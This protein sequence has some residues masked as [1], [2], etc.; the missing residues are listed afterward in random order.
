MAQSADRNDNRE[1]RARFDDIY[2]QYQRLRSGMDDVQR[3]LGELKVTVQ[4]DD[5]LIRVTVGPRGQLLDLRLDPGVYRE[6]QPDELADEI[7]AVT[8]A[9]VAKVTAEVQRLMG[10][11][12][13]AE[14]GAL[15]F[16]KDGNLG[17]LLSRQDVAWRD[18]A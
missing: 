7:V 10:S 2:G 13:P 4:S 16:L 18:N 11:L 14:S 1:L 5:G 3:S 12:L 17:T 9:A 6:W 8:A 15:R